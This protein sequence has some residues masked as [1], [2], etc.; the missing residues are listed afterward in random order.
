MDSATAQPLGG[1]S[2]RVYNSLWAYRH[3]S[4]K[5]AD[6][7]DLI[8]TYH[9]GEIEIRYFCG[10]KK[11]KEL[12]AKPPMRKTDEWRFVFE[13]AGYKTL[14]LLAPVELVYC[15]SHPQPAPVPEVK[16]PPVYLV[17]DRVGPHAVPH[18]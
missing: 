5:Y 16:I 13:K 6:S 17:E 18:E 10:P 7:T 1:V 8:G 15:G 12:K 9:S 4:V 2:L 11:I 3:N 14:E